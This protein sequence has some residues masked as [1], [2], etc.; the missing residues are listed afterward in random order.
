MP[1]NNTPG[2]ASQDVK[3]KW[4][5]MVFMGAAT[6]EGEED[7]LDAAE[8]DI[9]EMASVGSGPVGIGGNDGELSIFV[10]VYAHQ[11]SGKDRKSCARFGRVEQKKFVKKRQVGDVFNAFGDP[12]GSNSNA[13]T[14]PEAVQEFVTKA[15]LMEPN[16]DRDNPNHYSMFVLWGHAYDFAIGRAPTA[17]GTIDALDFAELSMVLKSLQNN[18]ARTR[19]S[20]FLGSMRAISRL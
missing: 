20:T 14:G 2:S 15:M 13:P 9:E 18:W 5:V 3:P 10:Q 17:E 12:V 4:M 19:S 1:E 8:D 7:L 11:G 6:I 16:F